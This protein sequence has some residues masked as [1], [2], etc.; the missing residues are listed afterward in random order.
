[1]RFSVPAL[2]LAIVAALTLPMA[3]P[4]ADANEERQ[5]RLEI[6]RAATARI[7]FREG[8]HVALF[9]RAELAYGE[10]TLMAESIEH[11]SAER[12]VT[13]SG[14]VRL[15]APE[16]ALNTVN[17]SV[18]L[19][20][21]H[22]VADG[23]FELVNITEGVTLKADRGSF[24]AE[25]TDNRVLRAE[26]AGNITAQWDEGITLQ[27]GLL[28]SDFEQRVHALTGDFTATINPALLPPPLDRLSGGVLSLTGRDLAVQ[29]EEG[30][31]QV[32]HLAANAVRIDGERL[33]LCGTDLKARLALTAEGKPLAE[34]GMLR[35][36]G[37]ASEPASGWLLNEQGERVSFSAQSVEKA[38]GANEL[39]LKDNV[40]VTGLDFCLY[41]QEVSVFQEDQGVRVTIPQ[42]FRV[43]ISPEVFQIRN[44][45]SDSSEDD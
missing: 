35:L 9:T 30:I 14:A 28:E 38:A 4:S 44:S 7:V 22:V 23:D 43:V 21:G 25:P 40:Q 29:L 41:A 33:G 3:H 32:F 45:V 26:L 11:N 18:D 20:S 6:T 8:Q 2:C 39:I 36:S 24:W 13:L 34:D 37:S 19:A 15:R 10:L 1:M 16:Y 42:R 31:P 12:T 5:P 27:G 17:C